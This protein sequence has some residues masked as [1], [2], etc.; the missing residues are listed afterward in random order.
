MF[1]ICGKVSFSGSTVERALIAKMCQR[2]VHRG[3]DDE[4]I[5]TAP[6]VGLGQRRLA[7]ID[8][9]KAAVAPLSNEDG[10]IGVTFNGEIYNFQ[11]L[12]ANLLAKGHIFRTATD[13]EVIVHLYEEYGTDFL[14]QLRGMFA[15]ALWDAKKKRLFAARDR[16][17]KKPFFYTKTATSLIFG[18]EL[19]AIIAAPEVSV[20]PNLQAIDAYLTWQY[21]PSPLTAFTGVFK[22]PAAHF[23]I[24]KANST[25]AIQRYWSPPLVEQKHTAPAELEEQ[26]VLRLKEAIRLRMIAD[27]PLGAFLSGGID[28]TSVVALM[29]EMS[30]QPVKTFSI[31]FEEK[32]YNELPDA[33]LVAERYG[34]DHHE[35]I[36]KPNAI[37]VLPL[38][39]RHYGEP[40]ADSSALPTFYVSK[41]TREHVT[42][43]LSGDGGD[44]NFCGYERYAEIA[45][46][47]KRDT[48]PFPL[49]HAIATGM[50]SILERLAYSNT[51][52]S[53]DRALQMFGALLPERYLLQ[54]STFKPQ[55]KHMCYTSHFQ[56][57]LAREPLS[58]NPVVSHEWDKSM[59]ELDWM[60]R[61]DQHFYLPDCL[62]VKVDVAS[63][64]NGLEVRCPFLDHRFVE[65]AATIPSTMKR[66]VGAGKQILKNAMRRFVP[67]QILTKRKTGFGVPLSQWFR[68]ELTD[69][70]RGA[71]LDNQAR[72]RNLFEPRF[73][74]HMIDEQIIGRRDWSSRLWALLCLELWFREFI[75]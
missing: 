1:G 64:A 61:H 7:I 75:D 17:G 53:L 63:M 65:F 8:L 50:V 25:L 68:G 19:Q 3:P 6:H 22:L 35:F 31:G 72:R 18:S 47:S 33:R 51:K 52:A 28:S 9:S 71:L 57:C 12:R 20:T 56:N 60:M 44:E 34:T 66:H 46:W 32:T 54:M 4:G 59:D 37:E 23:L 39:V 21:V 74:G 16:L 69:L 14:A 43:A 58:S 45:R 10:S 2:L 42:V 70:L 40:F 24:C 73:L 48:L 29:A 49:R 55:G 11:E 62:M 26:L 30:S 36:D 15:F 13:T 5:Y 27:V 67:A 41:L 38:L